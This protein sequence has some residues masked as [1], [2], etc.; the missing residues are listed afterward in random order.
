MNEKA[1]KYAPNDITMVAMALTDTQEGGG[2]GDERIVTEGVEGMIL[3]GDTST[4]VDAKF[5]RGKKNKSSS[6]SSSSSGPL[7]L[8]S[9]CAIVKGHLLKE[10]YNPNVAPM[11]VA[12]LSIAK[13]SF[14]MQD[15]HSTHPLVLLIQSIKAPYQHTLSIH[16]TNPHPIIKHP[17]NPLYQSTIYQITLSIHFTNRSYQ[18][19]LVL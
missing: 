12:F 2:E 9:L 18:L 15:N 3:A 4:N 8:P 7:P 11:L 5:S 13:V 10:R 16:F 19:I 17:V 14:T 1:C 6:S